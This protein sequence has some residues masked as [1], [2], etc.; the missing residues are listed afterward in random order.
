MSAGVLT[1]ETTPPGTDETTAGRAAS[2][3]I[4]HPAP[5]M[6]SGGAP[7][8]VEDHLVE[9]DAAKDD[10]AKDDAPAPTTTVEIEPTGDEA[11]VTPGD[12]AAEAAEAAESDEQAPSRRSVDVSAMV[13]LARSAAAQWRAVEG[14]SA[15]DLNADERGRARLAE[16]HTKLMTHAF[17]S[18]PEEVFIE[19][20][21][22]APPLETDRLP[23]A[24]EL[25]SVYAGL[26][27]WCDH[28]L[29]RI[30]PS[31]AA[32][33]AQQLDQHDGDH[34][35]LAPTSPAVT[36]PAVTSAYGYL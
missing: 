36:S 19:L 4:V 13:W 6:R 35:S 29:E 2:D 11:P 23:S 26:A 27:G 30:A 15:S 10:D 17:R 1:E 32:A 8:L 21:T 3:G 33:A 24:V 7:I 25:R 12:E 34:A 9:H 5:R 18:V 16:V 22:V 31:L 28:L 14:L 20:V